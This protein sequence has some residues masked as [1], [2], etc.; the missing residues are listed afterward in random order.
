[1]GTSNPKNKPRARRYLE[2]AHT[3]ILDFSETSAANAETLSRY[4]VICQEFPVMVLNNG[5]SQ[6]IAFAMSKKG[7]KDGLSAAYTRLLEDVAAILDLPNN[8]A[9]ATSTDALN[10]ISGADTPTYMLYTQSVLDA[11]VYFKRL[12]KSLLDAEEQ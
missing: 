9:A 11:W 8:N 2:L 1:M 4:R 12:S 3:R 6:A 7:D 5:L 10:G